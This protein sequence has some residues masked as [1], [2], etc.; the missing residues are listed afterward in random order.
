MH[1]SLRYRPPR[2]SRPG[3]PGGQPAMQ[4]GQYIELPLLRSSAHTLESASTATGARGTA[5]PVAGKFTRPLRTPVARASAM[6]LP[7]RRR[8]ARRR[9]GTS[10][11][12]LSLGVLDLRL[13]LAGA[14]RVGVALFRCPPVVAGTT[15]PSIRAAFAPQARP[16]PG[17]TPTCA[18][19]AIRAIPGCPSFA[20]PFHHGTGATPAADHFRADT[21]VP[22]FRASAGVVGQHFAIQGTSRS[23]STAGRRMAGANSGPVAPQVLPLAASKAA[24]T[25][26]TLA[27]IACPATAGPMRT[28][29]LRGA[30][31]GR[32]FQALHGQ[33]G[34]SC[35][36]V[37]GAMFSRL[38]TCSS[39]SRSRPGRRHWPAGGRTR[40][41]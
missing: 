25:P 2:C 19:G 24:T 31:A 8:P 29:P 33:A 28:L 6:T 39:S 37:G 3:P 23:P 14:P 36:S 34:L 12:S 4:K 41:P 40:F 35:A 17:S 18:T 7:R 20:H 27:V 38:T 13:A 21:D 26:S 1:R 11:P 32:G 15:L 5:T 16:L 9:R 30:V 10:S 22:A